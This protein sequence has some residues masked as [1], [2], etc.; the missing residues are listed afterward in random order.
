MHGGMLRLEDGAALT[1]KWAK[2]KSFM[3]GRLLRSHQHILS[4]DCH[5][6]NAIDPTCSTNS[7]YVAELK[8][9]PKRRRRARQQVDR[10]AVPVVRQLGPRGR[11]IARNYQ[12]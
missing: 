8:S 1:D 4:R 10:V 7:A 9:G 12:G 5:L 11:P 3:F 2:L 6:N